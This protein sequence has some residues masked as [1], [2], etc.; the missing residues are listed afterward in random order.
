MET[1]T[2][3]SPAETVGLKTLGLATVANTYTAA[4]RFS[5]D[6]QEAP[7]FYPR[8]VEF[9]PAW[10]LH[11][12]LRFRG[13][14][15]L[16]ENLPI[17]ISMG[18]T[19]PAMVDGQYVMCEEDVL[20]HLGG[21]DVSDEETELMKWMDKELGALLRHMKRGNDREDLAEVRKACGSFSPTTW[22]EHIREVMAAVLK[23]DKSAFGDE[24]NA[25]GG[26]DKLLERLKQ[27]LSKIEL[28]LAQNQ[29]YLFGPPA[30]ADHP[31]IKAGQSLRDRVSEAVLFGHLCEILCSSSA[32]TVTE[33]GQ[34]PTMMAFVRSVFADYFEMTLI[35][36]SIAIYD[37]KES[38]DARRKKVVEWRRSSDILAQNA[39]IRSLSL[40][41][42]TCVIPGLIQQKTKYTLLDERAEKAWRRLMTLSPLRNNCPEEDMTTSRWARVRFS[43]QPLRARIGKI[44]T[45][46]GIS[47]P[48]LLSQENEE[49]E[50]QESNREGVVTIT[51]GGAFFVSSIG[52]SFLG[53]LLIV[54]G[55]SNGFK[56]PT[57]LGA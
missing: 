12:L 30:G 54:G 47:A 22:E 11:A 1:L 53:Y 38:S 42:G 14:T 41:G 45:F 51:P 28:K 48:S 13:I 2:G 29:G 6:D 36:P 26:T 32:A 40:D 20:K 18:Q 33:D 31:G 39:F 21:E 7:T 49:K 19:L 50:T 37:K 10:K 35:P 56:F 34:Y 4:P 55:Y 8:L 23:H 15:Y 5:S 25:I 24:F 43:A 57:R 52:V 3:S 44:A 16:N 27:S 9:R 17:P 46:L